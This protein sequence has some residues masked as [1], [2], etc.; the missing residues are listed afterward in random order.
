MVATGEGSGRKGKG[1]L[2]SFHRKAVEHRTAR[3][4]A[5]EADVGH[6]VEVS[7]AEPGGTA[8]I[9]DLKKGADAIRRR[10]L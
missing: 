7:E 9:V 2:F 4:A 5:A 6:F 1:A 8:G 3:T 10:G